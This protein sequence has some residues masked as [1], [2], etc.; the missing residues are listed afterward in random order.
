MEDLLPFGALIIVSANS[1]I[2]DAGYL[3]LDKN[4]PGIQY[5]V[6]SLAETVIITLFCLLLTAYC[7][8]LTPNATS[9]SFHRKI[10]SKAG[11]YMSKLLRLIC[12]MLLS[13]TLSPAQTGKVI[14]GTV[15]DDQSGALQIPEYA[16]NAEAEDVTD[17]P[18]E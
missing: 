10:S 1:K 17:K 3:M 18:T 14:H 16:E 7:I 5:Q 12:L 2:L 11:S 13:F 15:K 4:L 6:I 9:P 8:L